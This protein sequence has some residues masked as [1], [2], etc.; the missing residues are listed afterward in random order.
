MD[1]DT[2]VVIAG[3]GG[4]ESSLLPLWTGLIGGVVG[5]AATYIA[6]KT[7]R[8]IAN[9]QLSQQATQHQQQLTAT[10]AIS[11]DQL[12]QQAA[13]HREQ[14]TA[15]IVSANR[16]RWIEL[17]RNEVAAFAA[18]VEGIVTNVDSD[19]SIENAYTMVDQ[20]NLHVATILLLVNHAEPD[21]K[22][23]VDEIER[24]SDVIDAM[25]K[26]DGRVDYPRV[27]AHIDRIGA[28]TRRLT[29]AEWVRVT[30]LS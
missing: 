8:A 9:D 23:L 25:M 1:L 12:S 29:D 21:G 28:L 17:I 11:K 26:E 6:A 27:K 2:L 13:Q 4:K 18:A 19:E 5:F 7:S 14:L 16:V 24:F 15:T 10:I 20:A 22:E 3:A 30:Q